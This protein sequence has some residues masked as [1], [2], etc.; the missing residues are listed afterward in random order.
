MAVS[1]SGTRHVVSF[2][3]FCNPLSS[4]DS[5]LQ[6]ISCGACAEHVA[7]F[8]VIHVSTVLSGCVNQTSRNL[9]LYEFSQTNMLTCVLK[10]WF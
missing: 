4:F 8:G 6:G 10:V 5:H 7:Q 1:P 3:L 9:T 2:V